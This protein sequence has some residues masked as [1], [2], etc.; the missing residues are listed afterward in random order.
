MGWFYVQNGERVGPV[1]ESEIKDKIQVGDLGAE[2]FVWIKGFDNWKAIKDTAEF[3]EVSAQSIPEPEEVDAPPVI[4]EISLGNYGDNEKRFFIRIGMDRGGV[5]TDYGPYTKA[6]LKKLYKENRING[7]TLFFTQGM[8]NWITLA[9]VKDFEQ[10]FEDVP[11]AIDDI[12]KRDSIRKPFIA[13]MFI[14]NND[15]VYEGLCRDISVGG[16]QVLVAEFPGSP[17]EKV[18]INVHPDNSDFN[19][20]AS[21]KIVRLLDGNSGFS[22]IF[23]NLDDTAKSSIQEY[24]SK[25]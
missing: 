20:T 18:N 21:G 6:V 14:A 16:M 8:V 19:F 12:E 24:I 1:E 15:K 22:F 9:E 2:D 10:V 3:A 5:A 13:K 17:G 4:E 7:K 11:P 23:E 25:S